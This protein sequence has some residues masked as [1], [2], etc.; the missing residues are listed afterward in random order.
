MSQ[1]STSDLIGRRVGRLVVIA[2]SHS[3]ECDG[4]RLCL[5]EWSE[6]SGLSSDRISKRLKNGWAP[7]EAI[8]APIRAQF[9]R[10]Q[11]H[12]YPTEGNP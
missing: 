8:F 9:A 1:M 6:L 5:S 3:V 2:F 12:A 7:R 4:S 11:P 10:Q